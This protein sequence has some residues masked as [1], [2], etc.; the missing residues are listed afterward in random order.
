MVKIFKTIRY[1]G[2]STQYSAALSNSFVTARK[3]ALISCTDFLEG[4]PSE[5]RGVSSS[6]VNSS[7]RLSPFIPV[8]VEGANMSLT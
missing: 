4:C 3:N 8:K 6:F 1:H 5:D 2:A 7:S